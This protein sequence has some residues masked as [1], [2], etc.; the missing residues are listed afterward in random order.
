MSV[1][2]ICTILFGTYISLATIG[3]VAEYDDAEED[4]AEAVSAVKA[5]CTQKQDTFASNCENWGGTFEGCT[6]ISGGMSCFCNYDG[7]SNVY[8]YEC[9]GPIGGPPPS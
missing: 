8:H 2:T 6:A 4:T 9:S 5:T 3:C 1:R 7:T